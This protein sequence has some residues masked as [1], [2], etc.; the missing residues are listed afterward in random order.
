[1][2]EW[3]NWTNPDVMLVHSIATYDGEMDD[4]SRLLSYT[5]MLLRCQR[6]KNRMKEKGNFVDLFISSH[7]K[8]NM[9]DCIKWW[10][11]FVNSEISKMK[12]GKLETSVQNEVGMSP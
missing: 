4:G 8:K 12:R 9:F 5:Y 7:I 6:I 1:M 11:M 10:S 2:W 3:A